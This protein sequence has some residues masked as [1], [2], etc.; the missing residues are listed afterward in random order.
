M[1]VGEAWII[2]GHLGVGEARLAGTLQFQPTHGLELGGGGR[3][4]PQ[5]S[6]CLHTTALP[7]R[8]VELG[9]GSSEETP[10]PKAILGHSLAESP[11]ERNLFSLNFLQI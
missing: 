7:R 1:D 11:W 10:G 8:E 4:S 9:H 6:F 3:Q 2:L 5:G